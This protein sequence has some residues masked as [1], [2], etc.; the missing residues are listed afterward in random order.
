MVR[1]TFTSAKGASLL[2]GPPGHAP[3]ENFQIWKPS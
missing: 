1:V 2:G 3:P